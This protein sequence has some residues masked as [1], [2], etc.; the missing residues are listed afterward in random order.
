MSLEGLF[1]AICPYMSHGTYTSKT[2]ILFWY[3][4]AEE[5]YSKEKS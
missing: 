2:T 4:V 1:S 3:I 5:E